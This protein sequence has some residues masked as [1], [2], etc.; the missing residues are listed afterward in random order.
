[1]NS[2]DPALKILIDRFCAIAS[3]KAELERRIE[4]IQRQLLPPKS[5]VKFENKVL[6]LN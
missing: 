1:M 5:I 4:E 3:E 2:D 6:Y